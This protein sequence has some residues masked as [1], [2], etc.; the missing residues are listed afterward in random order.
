MRAYRI[1]GAKAEVI[2]FLDA[3]QPET[4]LGGSSQIEDIHQSTEFVVAT[5][6]KIRVGN[7]IA[8]FDKPGLYRF[9]LSV[10]NDP[11]GRQFIAD[12]GDTVAFCQSLSWCFRHGHTD[13]NVV[14]NKP[15]SNDVGHAIDVIKF[16]NLRMGCGS[17]ARFT[18]HLHLL[19]TGKARVIYLSNEN[20]VWGGAHVM[21]ELFCAQRDRWILFDLDIKC[22]FE[23]DGEPASLEDL[24]RAKRDPKR[25]FTFRGFGHG[26]RLRF[27]GKG[28]SKLNKGYFDFLG[29][30]R[31]GTQAGISQFWQKFSAEL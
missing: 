29:D 24:R 14:F 27:S 28:L 1:S 5:G 7:K 4:A 2:Q 16:R 8:V 13:N 6:F 25:T 12:D 18:A 15:M 10:G 17:V 23:V 19:K 26:K 9:C 31:L 3:A 21:V 30:Y 20:A 22:Y 11:W